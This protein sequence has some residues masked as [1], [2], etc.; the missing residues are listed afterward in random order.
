MS[1]ILIQVW[2]YYDFP[3]KLNLLLPKSEQQN[4]DFCDK[5]SSEHVHTYVSKMFSLKAILTKKL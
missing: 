4:N 1:H 2:W 5:G 3:F